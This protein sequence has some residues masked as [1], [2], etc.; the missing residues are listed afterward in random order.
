MGGRVLPWS[1]LL[2]VSVIYVL[3]RETRRK[4]RFVSP[5]DRAHWSKRRPRIKPRTPPVDATAPPPVVWQLARPLSWS[6]GPPPLL[7]TDRP[8]AVEV[9][10]AIEAD[11]R[12]TPS[13]SARQLKRK[14]QNAANGT[15]TSTGHQVMCSLVFFRVL[16]SMF[17]PSGTGVRRTEVSFV[18][19]LDLS[20][21]QFK[22][23]STSRVDIYYT[24]LFL[25]SASLV[26]RFCLLKAWKV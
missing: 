16:H 23:M 18:A 25:Y 4:A 20:D 17:C 5:T 2:L 21:T 7:L 24:Y 14:R 11:I 12:G 3:T 15:A 22:D 13:Y 19:I 6:T 10:A 8:V 26:S 1:F 9:E